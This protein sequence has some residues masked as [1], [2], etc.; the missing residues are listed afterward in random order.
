MSDV[1]DEETLAAGSKLTSESEGMTENAEEWILG[2]ISVPK[3]NVGQHRPGDMPTYRRGWTFRVDE[4]MDF[5]I[6]PFTNHRGEPSLAVLLRGANEE[7][8]AGWFRASRAEEVAHIVTQLNYELQAERERCRTEDTISVSV[9]SVFAPDAPWG[10]ER[11][12]IWSDGRIA[13]VRRDSDGSTRRTSGTIPVDVW[14]RVSSALA[15]T[16]FPEQPD[17][18]IL[19]GGGPPIIEATGSKRGRVVVDELENAG[20]EDYR[21]VV[22]TLYDFAAAVR[23]E[24]GSTLAKLG[25]KGA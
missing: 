9:G 21:T 14:R 23:N 15:R 6:R 13:Y 2:M 4:E 3:S 22:D 5:I 20:L 1:Y 16:T 25:F 7:F 24:D 17:I 11:V 19:P 8:F 12:T 18:D 10:S